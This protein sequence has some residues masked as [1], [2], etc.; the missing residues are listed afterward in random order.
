MNKNI[1]FIPAIYIIILFIA[2]NTSAQD[3]T[4]QQ[5]GD[6]Y[7][8]QVADMYFEVDQNFGS[9]ISSLKLGDNEVMFVNRDYADPILWGS[10]LW[11]APQSVWNWPPSTTL[12]SD[13][14]S[15]GLPQTRILPRFRHPE[16]PCVFIR[17]MPF[18]PPGCTSP[19]FPEEDGEM[20]GLRES[21]SR[22]ALQRA[23]TPP[24]P[25]CGVTV[26]VSARNRFDCRWR[27]RG[28]YLRR[29]PARWLHV[30]PAQWSRGSG[31]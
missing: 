28:L 8:F 21:E 7:S 25:S 15:G 9:R 16:N 5:N 27:C 19:G 31:R 10:T 13:P 20:L 26:C 11:P 6:L 2:L 18:L 23:G 30:L 12:D 3:I 17:G 29:W 4:P 24:G 22:N 14:Y 1:N